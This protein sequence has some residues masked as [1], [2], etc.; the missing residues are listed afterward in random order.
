MAACRYPHF[1]YF[2][3]PLLFACFCA[4]ADE[5][6]LLGV[7]EQDAELGSSPSPESETSTTTETQSTEGTETD[8][9]DDDA[10]PIEMLIG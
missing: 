8:D 5:F 2:E 4:T 6:L 7:A 3:H 1:A 10:W 9:E